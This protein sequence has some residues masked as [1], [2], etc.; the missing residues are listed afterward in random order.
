MKKIV[1]GKLYSTETAECVGSDQY[2]NPRDFHYWCETLYRKK[3]GEYFLHG[4]GNGLSH[5]RTYYSENSWGGGEE[6]I[7]MSFDAAKKWAETHLD[8]DEYIEEFGD[9]AE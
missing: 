2:S 8:A 3:N 1:N 7:P 4:E 6:I 9:P 5:Y